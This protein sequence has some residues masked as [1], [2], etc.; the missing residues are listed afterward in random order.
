MCT[1]SVLLKRQHI[2][3]KGN[4]KTMWE[5]YLKYWRPF[6]EVLTNIEREG[7]KLDMQH[8]KAIETAAKTD[9]K[10]KEEYFINFLKQFQTG[11]N[12]D[13]FNPSSNLQLQ[14]LFYAPYE[15]KPLEP[16]KPASSHLSDQEA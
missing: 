7:I 12:I 4:L 14:Q 16:S 3:L 2:G 10:Q 13:H 1:H 15:I 11:Q 8:M 5:L 9:L 6:G